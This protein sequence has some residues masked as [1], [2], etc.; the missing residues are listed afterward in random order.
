MIFLN[1]IEHLFGGICQ[2]DA[3]VSFP[4]T[5]RGLTVIVF[6]RKVDVAQSFHSSRAY[7][8]NNCNFV[9]L[10]YD[11]FLIF[12]HVDIFQINRNKTAL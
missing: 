3:S 6:Q 1:D 9:A 7:W 2:A 4:A 10:I 8:R 5:R 12:G 11:H